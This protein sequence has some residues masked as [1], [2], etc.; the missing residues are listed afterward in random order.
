M[1]K[2]LLILE[3]M[4]P[5]RNHN[6][7]LLLRIAKH[8]DYDGEILATTVC[9]NYN[10]SAKDKKKQCRSK[11][12][13]GIP[14]VH[15]KIGFLGRFFE[16]IIARMKN[17]DSASTLIKML[18][19]YSKNIV[20]ARKA[21]VILYT[22]KGISSSLAAS[23]LKSKKDAIKALYLLDPSKA[24][25]DSTMS[26]NDESPRFIEMLKN[27]DIVF[28]TSF[29]KEAMIA[30]GYGDIAK[31]IIEVAF[32]MVIGFDAKPRNTTSGK[33]TLLYC[34]SLYLQSQIRSP[35]YLFDIIERLDNRFRIIFIGGES[36]AAVSQLPSDIVPEVI[37]LP[38]MQREEL[39]EYIAEADFLINIGNSVPVHLPSKVLEYINTGKPI[40]NFYK[41][42]N[43][44]SLHYTLKYPLSLNLDEKD[45]DIASAA[46]KLTS[47]CIG[48]K[49]KQL[50]QGWV[51]HNYKEA[52]PKAIAEK[53]MK[54][55]D[56]LRS[57]R[58][59]KH[60]R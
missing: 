57:E 54:E 48:N 15:I 44:P 42:D 19:L 33:I 4:H 38:Q 28:T 6:S 49:G 16:R 53:I 52:T 40:I 55:C 2:V 3:S 56:K 58:S 23:K 25:Y 29:I 8:M 30:K 17:N 21:D 13:D 10:G 27:S 1:E 26:I 32:P 39:Q 14:T 34:G 35:R 46:E 22:Y 5:I 41:L 24:I 36:K 43:C 18:K 51:Q 47:F 20:R 31:R 50:E 12:I 45:Q 9:S 37:A 60:A 59:T 7:N 11:E